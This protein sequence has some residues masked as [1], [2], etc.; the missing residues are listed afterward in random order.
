M[1]AARLMVAGATSGARSAP[2]GAKEYYELAQSYS[3]TIQDDWIEE[4]ERTHGVKL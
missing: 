1:D 4:L 2:A 3:I